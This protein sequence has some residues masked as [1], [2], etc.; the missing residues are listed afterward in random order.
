MWRLTRWLIFSWCIVG[1][2]FAANGDPVDINQAD[3]QTLQETMTGVGPS[4]AQAIIEYR[5]EHGPFTS[6]DQLD[7]VVGIGSATIEKNRSRITAIPSQE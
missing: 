3:A 5:D 1:G 6:V 7:L 2:A 4:K